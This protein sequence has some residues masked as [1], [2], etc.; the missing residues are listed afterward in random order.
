M[1]IPLEE[2]HEL[3]ERTFRRNVKSKRLKPWE[4]LGKVLAEDV[5]SPIDVPEA[6]LAAMDGFA[7]R[8]EDLERLN[9]LKIVG[10]S[11]PSGGPLPT[12]REGEAVYVTTGAPI[13]PGADAV[14]RV[15]AVKVEGNLLFTQAKVK[16]GKD[17]KPIG[18]DFKKGDELL[19]SGKVV[20]ERDL[21]LLL[22]A[23]VEEVAVLNYR[24]CVIATGDELVPYYS[25][26]TS[27]VRDSI[28]PTIA[29]YLSKFGEALYLGVMP[30]SKE[31]IESAISIATETC[32]LT[33]VIGGSSMGEKDFVKKAIAELG[34]L[35][36]EGVNVNV[37][38]RCGVGVVKGKPVISLPGQVVSAVTSFH[39]FGLHVIEVLSGVKLRE[40][41]TAELDEDLE[42]RHNMDPVY[43]FAV[44]GNKARPLRW[45]VGLYS[46]LVKASGY[47][48][49]QRGRKYVKGEMVEV[50]KFI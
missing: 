49:L 8:A 15:E 29:A 23:G 46:E 32:D 39:E 42:V 17:I 22:R 5:K 48:V 47:A 11:F 1:L 44:N 9:S 18:E 19:R 16:P 37:I 10:K 31:K 12:V 6:P 34:T 27:K 41:I 28:G 20:N 4:A 7:V 26:G 24:S 50:R 2:A 14:I 43:L 3:I 40:S 30:D 21:A 36:F 35:L 25:T 38:K 13:P 45:G 33:F